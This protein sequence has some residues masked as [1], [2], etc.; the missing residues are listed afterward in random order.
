MQL[1]KQYFEKVLGSEISSFKIE[2]GV[3]YIEFKLPEKI[4]EVVTS[5]VKWFNKERGHGFV[6]MEDGPDVFVH[7]T[8]II[9][10]KSK[11][12]N[13]EPGDNVSFVIGTDDRGRT[14]ALK[15]RKIDS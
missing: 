2:D 7:Y 4:E 9:D 3:V 8:D 5:T 10:I 11:I 15:L 12:K 6:F 1:N 14:R 13:L